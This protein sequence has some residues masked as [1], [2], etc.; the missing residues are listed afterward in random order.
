[1]F[2]DEIPE[3]HEV[4]NEVPKLFL[5]LCQSDNAE[6]KTTALKTTT[7]ILMLFNDSERES[8]YDI[9]CKCICFENDPTLRY[10]T[11]QFTEPLLPKIEKRFYN[12]CT[13]THTA[14][15]AR[16]V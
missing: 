13:F 6:V 1:M 16:N 3:L 7:A 2:L 4:W 12:T 8:F 11:N 5:N 9:I 14:S 15:K 10:L